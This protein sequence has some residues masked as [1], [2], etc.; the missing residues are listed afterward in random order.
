MAERYA[1]NRNLIDSREQEILRGKTVAVVGLGGLGGYIAEQLARLGF[2]RL[3]LIDGD[4]ADESNLNRQLF[5]TERTIGI[6]KA[7]LAVERLRQVNSLVEYR[8]HHARLTPENGIKLLGGADI[9]VD[10]VD[11]IR[12][13]LMLQELCGQ[14]NVPLVHGSIGGWW[15]Q[16]SVIFPGED[17]LSRIY[18]KEDVIG[19]EQEFGNPA[20]TPGIIASI[21]VSETLKICLGRPGVLRGKLLRVDLLEHDYF[22]FEL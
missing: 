18:P 21:Q 14:L 15:G 20:F 2:G 13:R 3:I 22:V 9:V 19:I 16:V 5:A 7:D 12:A 1:R 11:S 10:A 8:S 17:T 4:I 6:S